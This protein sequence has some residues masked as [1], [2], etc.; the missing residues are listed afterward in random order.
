MKVVLSVDSDEFGG[1]ENSLVN[2]V[3]SSDSR[4]QFHLVGPN[5]IGLQELSRRLPDLPVSFVKTHGPKKLRTVYEYR[6]VLA[7]IG[8]DILQVT[9]CNPGAAIAVQLAGVSL[10]LNTIAVE[11]LV[12]PLGYTP[13]RIVKRLISRFLVD[14]V[15]VGAYSSRQV[16]TLFWLPKGSVRTIY[17]GVDDIDVKPHDFGAGP[18]VGTV[19][20]LGVQKGLDRLIDA[21]A[22]VASV[23]LVIVGGGEL[24]ERLQSQAE[25]LGISDRVMFLGWRDNPRTFL[26]GFD[27]FVLPSRNEAFPLSIVEAML[28]SVPVIA[29]DVGSVSEAIEDGVTGFLVPPN[30]PEMIA[31]KIKDVLA[32]KHNIEAIT[33]AARNLAV[34]K[35]TRQTM[36]QKY[37][38]MWTRPR[39]RMLLRPIIFNKK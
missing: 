3:Q 38:D 36:A 32:E 30:R 21:V 23:K 33:L 25:D 29:T 18:T 31:S 5:A 37:A 6:K 39:G 11:Q 24:L 2:L 9:L 7:S 34:S 19:A 15:A 10:G 22:N 35:F 4:Y 16:E 8:P 1:A 20:R 27:V 28:C 26:A 14:H 13:G 17:N 12:R